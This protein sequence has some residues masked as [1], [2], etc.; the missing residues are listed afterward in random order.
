MVSHNACHRHSHPERDNPK[1]N[2]TFW[3]YTKII[4]ITLTENKQLEKFFYPPPPTQTEKKYPKKGTTFFRFSNISLSLVTFWWQKIIFFVTKKWLN[5]AVKISKNEKS[6]P[7]FGV[8]FSVWGDKKKSNFSNYT[9]R[10]FC[11]ISARCSNSWREYFSSLQH[12][13]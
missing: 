1:T 13:L 2:Y 12:I 3:T 5:S 8:F 4:Q 10:N 6:C 9:C 11:I 7:L